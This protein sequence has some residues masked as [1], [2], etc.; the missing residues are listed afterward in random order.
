MVFL[1]VEREILT[2][3]RSKN[4]VTDIPGSEGKPSPV[5]IIILLR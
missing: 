5:K 4:C 3:L 1:D 2:A